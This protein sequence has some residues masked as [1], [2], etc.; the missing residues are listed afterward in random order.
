M[1]LSNKME[2][3]DDE[4]LLHKVGRHI[5]RGLPHHAK[6]HAEKIENALNDHDYYVDRLDK[7]SEEEQPDRSPGLRISKEIQKMK[8]SLD[9]DGDKHT[10]KAH[11]KTSH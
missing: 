11:Y 5:E 8:N 9:D 2:E 10:H 6:R 7:S 4:S 1:D 3:D